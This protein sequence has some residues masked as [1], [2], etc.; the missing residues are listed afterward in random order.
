MSQRRDTMNVIERDT[1]LR[2]LLLRPLCAKN[3]K[4]TVPEIEGLVDREQLM[5]FT[6]RGRREQ[7]DLALSLGI[8]EADIPTPAGGCLLTDEHIAG[9]A[10]R[11]F[12][13]AA[14]AIPG[15]AELRLATVG[16]HFSLT[17][18]CLLA[19]SRSKQENELMSGMQYPGNTFLRMQ[20]VPGPLAILRGT[21]GPD[22]LALAA[23][24]CLR[25]TKRRGEDGLVAAY[26]PTPACDQGRVAAPVMSEEAVRALL[27][28]LQA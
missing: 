11:A 5:G 22:E 12:K 26:G 4:P 14:P 25:Y 21:A 16:R 3:M 6:G 18:D 28:D 27:I 8:K 15:L 19:V 7:I 23:A 24:I 17:E 1:D 13:K 20:A 2:G 9:R 10:R